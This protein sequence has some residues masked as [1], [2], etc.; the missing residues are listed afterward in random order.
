MELTSKKICQQPWKF[1]QFVLVLAL[2]NLAGVLA[3]GVGLFF[4]APITFA[5]MMY[6]YED[7]FSSQGIAAAPEPVGVQASAIA[8]P[9]PT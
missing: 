3:F 5:A 6:A 7:V 2:L 9:Q 8:Q 1:L 4:T